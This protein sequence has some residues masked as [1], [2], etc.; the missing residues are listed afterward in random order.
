MQDVMYHPKARAHM[1]RY[2]PNLMSYKRMMWLDVFPCDT[3]VV[4][5]YEY[6][7]PSP[8]TKDQVCRRHPKYPRQKEYAPVIYRY[9]TFDQLW[10]EFQKEHVAIADK[11]RNNNHPNECPSALRTYASWNLIKGKILLN[12]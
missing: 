9:E 2:E 10:T 3:I 4:F 1:V 5:H 6:N 12:M 11:L 8:N 7:H